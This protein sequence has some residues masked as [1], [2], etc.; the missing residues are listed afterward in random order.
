MD[1]SRSLFVEEK[2]VVAGET[3]VSGRVSLMCEIHLIQPLEEAKD[4]EV[5]TPGREA[6]V[7]GYH[8]GG[9]ITL[10]WK[11]GCLFHPDKKKGGKDG[12]R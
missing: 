10:T 9:Q 2:K 3:P 4:A 11:E 5:K 12:C 1:N 8:T 7:D 6:E